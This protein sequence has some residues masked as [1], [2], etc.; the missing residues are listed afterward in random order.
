MHLLYMYQAALGSAGGFAAASAS[1]GH[2]I[3]ELVQGRPEPV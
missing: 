1:G 3:Q 2:P